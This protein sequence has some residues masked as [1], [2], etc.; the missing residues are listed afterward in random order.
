MFGLT[1]LFCW[2]ITFSGRILAGWFC[3]FTGSFIPVTRWDGWFTVWGKLIRWLVLL[4]LSL[5]LRAHQKLAGF[6]SLFGWISIEYWTTVALFL[7]SLLPNP[8]AVVSPY[9]VRQSTCLYSCLFAG[10]SFHSLQVWIWVSVLPSSHFSS[11]CRCGMPVLIGPLIIVLLVWAHCFDGWLLT[12]CTRF[13]LLSGWSRFWLS[14]VL[15]W[16]CWLS[17]CFRSLTLPRI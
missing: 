14:S 4:W 10:H 13:I 9:S 16:A 6:V 5:C 3:W 11:R 8:C 1:R 15:L 2:C 12:T 7:Q 17:R